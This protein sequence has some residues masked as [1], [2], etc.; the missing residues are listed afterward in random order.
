[1]LI[2]PLRPPRTELDLAS[3]VAASPAELA[4]WVWE[5]IYMYIDLSIEFLSL[6]PMY[7][8]II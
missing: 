8:I 1:M 4:T 6:K 2:A 7:A 3:A 5:T